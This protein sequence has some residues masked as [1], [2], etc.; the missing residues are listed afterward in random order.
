VLVA[1]TV[2]A[3]LA[4]FGFLGRMPSD[5]VKREDTTNTSLAAEQANV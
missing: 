2:A 4:I 5:T 3:A 1:I